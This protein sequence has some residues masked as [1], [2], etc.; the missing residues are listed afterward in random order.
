M[1]GS[2]TFFT[3]VELTGLLD[4][5]WQVQSVTPTPSSTRSNGLKSTGDQSVSTLSNKII[6][7]TGDAECPEL[8][9]DLV[10][11]AVGTVTAGGVHLDSITLTIAPNALP[12]LSFTAHKHDNG[13]T[14]AAASCRT[15]TPTIEFAAGFGIDRAGIGFTL[16]EGDTAI[17]LS[18]VEY[19][20]AVTH[21]DVTG[22]EGNWLA[23]ENRNG[24]EKFKLTT[25]GVGATVTAPTDETHAWDKIRGSTPTS[26]QSADSES[27]EYEHAVEL[28]AEA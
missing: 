2:I 13:A 26:N 11:P 22:D 9:G 3:P 17:G 16:A 7:Y 21:E 6:N 19:S 4:A 20:L 25:T 27:F 23:G 28:D 1:A 8:T 18:A 10:L 24:V 15:Y 12:K 14:H 5:T